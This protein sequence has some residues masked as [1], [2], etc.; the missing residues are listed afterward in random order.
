MELEQEKLIDEVLW[1]SLQ[2]EMEELWAAANGAQEECRQ[3][4]EEMQ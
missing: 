1:W 2:A 3:Y 4:K